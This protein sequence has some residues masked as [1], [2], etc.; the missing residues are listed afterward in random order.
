MRLREFEPQT[1]DLSPIRLL[2][3]DDG[4]AVLLLRLSLSRGLQRD[5]LGVVLKVGPARFFRRHGL[6]Q[7]LNLKDR[8]GC[9]VRIRLQGLGGVEPWLGE[10]SRE[11]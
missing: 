6:E 2:G 10:T 4:L 5:E 3:W 11:G 1:L 9:L 8:H 7:G